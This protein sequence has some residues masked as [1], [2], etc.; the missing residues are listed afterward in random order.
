EVAVVVE[1]AGG[2]PAAD[3]LGRERSARGAPHLREAPSVGVAEEQLALAVGGAG[4]K[5]R[6]VLQDV[7][8]GDRDV[9][10]P[11]VVVVEEADA[12]ADEWQ[13]RV[14]DPAFDRG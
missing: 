11:V 6:G 4:T 3:A 1:V 2:Q 5:L 8:V 9:E 7:A 12:E 14:A 10:Q 13:G